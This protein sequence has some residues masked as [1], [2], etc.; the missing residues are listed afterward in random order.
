MLQAKH[1]KDGCMFYRATVPVSLK[2]AAKRVGFL[3]SSAKTA[4]SWSTEIN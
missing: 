2:D 3:W 1:P 4:C